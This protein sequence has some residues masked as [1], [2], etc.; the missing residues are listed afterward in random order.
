[1][2]L[3]PLPPEPKPR[4]DSEMV[5]LISEADK[6]LNYLDGILSI[7]PETHYLPAILTVIEAIN[8][9]RVDN[10]E[11]SPRDFFY[12]SLNENSERVNK[13]L[14]YTA[15]L[16]VGKKLIKNV[17]SSSHIIKSVYKEL[18]TGADS[19]EYRKTQIWVGQQ[20][21]N[22][23]DARYIPPSHDEVPTLMNDLENYVASDISYPVVVNAALIH[24]Q[25]EMIHPFSE[26]NGLVGRILFVLHLLWKKKLNLP[27]LQ[28]SS[29]LFKNK[30]EYFDHLE[31]LERTKNWEAWIKFFVRTVSSATQSTLELIKRIVALEE[32]DYQKIVGKEFA[33]S[34]SLRLFEL[35]LRQPALTIPFITKELGF[36]KQ[37]ANILIKKFLDENILE[38]TTGKQRN[39]I[40]VYND[41]LN[42]L[43]V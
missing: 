7:F 27:G 33:S 3:Q 5:S 41:Y 13:I 26:R 8:S 23:V 35:M 30:L 38:E 37:T 32:H 16:S 15:A 42:I 6:Q 4:L 18:K 24:A 34:F 12:E 2:H 10:E 31:N 20:K 14:N 21:D 1:M 17:S 11:L 28:I 29:Q 19:G 40:F 43:E 9:N 22:L 36:N 39:R 25:F